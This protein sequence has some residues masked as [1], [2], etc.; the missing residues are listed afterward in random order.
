MQIYVYLIELHVMST[1]S[2]DLIRHV[3]ETHKENVL[4]IVS[5]NRI[6]SS[7]WCQDRRSDW[8]RQFTSESNYRRLSRIH[9]YVFK[10]LYEHR[11]GSLYTFK[12]KILLPVSHRNQGPIIGGTHRTNTRQQAALRMDATEEFHLRD[13]S[14]S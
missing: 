6:N 13:V 8:N 5:K 11:I 3:L 9:R 7:Q 4:I 12:H 14:A 2:K 10:Y 1:T